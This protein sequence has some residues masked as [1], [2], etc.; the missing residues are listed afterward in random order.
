MFHGDNAKIDE[1]LCIGADAADRETALCSAVL[2]NSIE[3]RIFPLLL[4]NGWDPN[5]IQNELTIYCATFRRDV[6]T[7]RKLL[8][9]GSAPWGSMPALYLATLQDS[10]GL[11]ENLVL[12]G[13]DTNANSGE[14]PLVS[15]H[16]PRRSV[17]C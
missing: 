14:P 7:V 8:A 9:S 1:M 15:C 2:N 12:K 5:S 10:I 17:D 3:P 13:A 6:N 11:V 16:V 4:D